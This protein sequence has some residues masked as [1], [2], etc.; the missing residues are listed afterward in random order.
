VL[1][2]ALRQSN[3][4][5]S[6]WHLLRAAKAA[7]Q[8][9]SSTELTTLLASAIEQLNS[10]IKRGDKPSVP[11]LD[12]VLIQLNGLIGILDRSKALL[13]QAIVAGTEECE[14]EPFL[15]AL[16]ECGTLAEEEVAELLMLV[17]SVAGP[18][19]SFAAALQAQGMAEEALQILRPLVE[20]PVA[21]EAIFLD[22]AVA[23]K[24]AGS[25]AELAVLAAAGSRFPESLALARA[26]CQVAMELGDLAIA[27]SA[28]EQIYRAEPGDLHA[29]LN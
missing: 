22:A 11:G 8:A 20:S 18:L 6:A 5:I 3:D 29:I 27:A 7:R 23:E 9:G 25:G 17:P 15:A 21:T 1:V 14:V 16:S 28:A 13:A 4:P 19:H 10:L 12:E 2:E 26:R 24:R